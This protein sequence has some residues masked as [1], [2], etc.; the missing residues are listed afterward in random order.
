MVSGPCPQDVDGNLIF[1]RGES[2]QTVNSWDPNKMLPNRSITDYQQSAAFDCYVDSQYGVDDYPLPYR[3]AELSRVQ[4]I[5]NPTIVGSDHQAHRL[6]VVTQWIKQLRENLS[7]ERKET[8]QV[9]VIP[10]TSGKAM[11]RLLSQIEFEF[12]FRDLDDAA[13]DTLLLDLKNVHEQV[14]EKA[15]DQQDFH[16]WKDRA[17]G[18]SSPSEM[19]DPLHEILYEDMNFLAEKG[20]LRDTSYNM[21]LISDGML[22][23]IKE[24]VDLA[25]GTHYKC[26]QCTVNDTD[27]PSSCQEIR[28]ELEE[29]LGRSD[30]NSHKM[31]TLKMGKIQA[32]RNLFGAGRIVNNFVQINQRYYEKIYADFESLFEILSEEFDKYK[33]KY[34]YWEL[35][36]DEL[37]FDLSVNQIEYQNF[38]LTGTIILNPNVRVFSDGSLHHDS[39]ADGLL[40]RD[41][42]V[43]GTNPLNP[44]SDGVCLDSMSVHPAYQEK[45][46]SLTQVLDCDAHLDTD[47]D[48]LNE[49][50]E[51]LLGTD[52]FDF[53]TDNDLIPDYFEWTYQ[54]NPLL[55]ERNHD[56]NGDGVTNLQAFLAGLGPAHSFENID[57]NF[58]V[59]FQVDEEVTE[60]R[61]GDMWINA[62]TI[63]IGNMPFKSQL[64]AGEIPLQDS[65]LLYHTRNL[66]G[67]GK[68][69]EVN[70]IK[71]NELLFHTNRSPDTNKAIALLR[72]RDKNNESRLVWKIM[73]FNVSMQ[74]YKINNLD[75]SGFSDFAVLDEV[76]D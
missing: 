13:L 30:L 31:L 49:C 52:P 3:N 17:M 42:K 35:N 75:L 16:R 60:Q 41:E 59:S 68:T 14:R 67:K 2:R 21:F 72:L 36:G 24:Q 71:L 70:S 39:D 48:S 20:A 26:H 51:I 1:K 40:D 34:K 44:R 43:M 53:D 32:L 45:C 6:S 8:A 47:M 61:R 29:S 37:P 4:V 46:A 7:A 11:Q 22:T 62:F 28:Q 57:K 19:F 15:M 56:T 63:D 73:K 76:N 54:F 27:C 58:L 18:A 50:E 25:V 33:Y 5:Q 10:Y 9:L 23:P 65:C 69:C 64:I 12:R 38:L 74:S 55:N 66:G